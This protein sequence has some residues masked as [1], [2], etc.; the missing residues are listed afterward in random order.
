MDEEFQ[1]LLKK[2]NIPV[3]VASVGDRK[4]DL[5]NLL[6]LCV[7]EARLCSTFF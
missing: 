2:P 4:I 7:A 1:R 6:F 3:N 5:F